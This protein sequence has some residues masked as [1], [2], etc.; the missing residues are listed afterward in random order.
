ME[1][2]CLTPMT[3]HAAC[4][5]LDINR[6]S[7]LLMTLVGNPKW[8]NTCFIYNVAVSS[9]VI[10]SLHGMNIAALVQPWSVMVRMESKPCETGSL[11]MKSSATVSNGI[12]SGLGYIG[13]KGA[14]VGQLLTLWR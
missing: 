6:G 3:L 12:A 4:M 5:N 7:Q 9:A 14:L 2:A 8:A 10:S 13:C 1:G 11:T